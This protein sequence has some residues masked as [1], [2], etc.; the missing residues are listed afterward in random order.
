MGWKSSL[1]LCDFLSLSLGTLEVPG[2]GDRNRRPMDPDERGSRW[3]DLHPLSYPHRGFRLSGFVYLYPS[4]TLLCSF[5]LTPSS[6]LSSGHQPLVES[7][8]PLRCLEIKAS[9]TRPIRV[10]IV[11]HHFALKAELCNVIQCVKCITPSLT[12]FKVLCN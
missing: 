3:L 4:H 1:G 5:T 6:P 12:H 8:I 2:A 7:P 11:T 10:Y 9:M